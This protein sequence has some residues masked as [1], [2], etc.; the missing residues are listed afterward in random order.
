ML[1]K[2]MS[3]LINGNPA[4]ESYPV[5]PPYTGWGR[6]LFTPNRPPVYIDLPGVRS[7]DQ[8]SNQIVNLRYR[9]NG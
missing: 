8:P 1:R 6:S 4:Y 7:L 3:F 2:L 5:K 9:I